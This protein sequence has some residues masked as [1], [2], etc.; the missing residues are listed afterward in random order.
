MKIIFIGGRSIHI[1]GGIENYMLNLTRELAKLGHECV[2]WCESDHR[3]VEYLDGVKIIYHPGPKSNLICKPWCGLKATVRTLMHEKNVDFVHYNAWP[4]SLWNWLPRMFGIQT[5]MEGHGLEWQRSKYSKLSQ[6]IMKYMEWFTA[7]INNH[8]IMC[9]ESQVR[10]FKKQYGKT[11]VC[12]P[13]AVVLPNVSATCNSDILEKY[14]LQ[15]QRYFLFMGRLVQDKNPDY[16]IRAFGKVK[17]LGYKLV[18]AGSNDTCPE[19]V[20]KLKKMANNDVVFT[21]AIYGEDKMQILKNAFCFCL[22]STIEGLSIVL[23]EATSYKLPV[24]ATNI[25]ANEEFL[26]NDAIYVTPE[27]EI[28]LTQ[29]I[30][31]A[32]S[33]PQ[34]LKEQVDANYTKL[35]SHY[36]WDKIAIKYVEYLNSLGIK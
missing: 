10:Y 11:A 19:Y 21:G 33:N 27:N 7:H 9:S 22:P 3:E 4:A 17:T 14:N 25:E 24:I 36:T 31:Y 29:A 15:P 30:E 13:G 16:L 12:I 1:L 26:G 8:L 34:K 18:I 20:E 5:A 32:I 6:T 35:V 23:M 28:E 2:V